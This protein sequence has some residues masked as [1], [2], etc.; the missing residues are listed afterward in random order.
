MVAKKVSKTNT[1]KMDVKSKTDAKLKS[2]VKTSKDSK[3]AKSEKKTVK[4]EKPSMVANGHLVS[5]E[6]VGTLDSGEEFDNSKN[7]GPIQFVVGSG[8]VIKG[9]DTAVLG[10]KVNQSKKFNIPKNEG[11]GDINPEMVQVVPLEKIPD[12]IKSQL[13]VGGFLVMQAP[14]GQQIPAKVLKMDKKTVSLDMNHPLAGKNLTFNIKV[15]DINVAPEAGDCCGGGC[16]DG[17]C[18]DDGCGDECACGHDH[19]G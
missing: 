9:F 4:V 2:D 10:M 12:H 7:H 11:Y 8:Q 19:K 5:V 17:D 1:S 14:T 6:Y 15:V 16:G 18:G 13:K 3:T